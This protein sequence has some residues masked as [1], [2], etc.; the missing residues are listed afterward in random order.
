MTLYQLFAMNGY[1]IRETYWETFDG[2]MFGPAMRKLVI[3]ADFNGEV[4]DTNAALARFEFD[5]WRQAGWAAATGQIT[6][7]IQPY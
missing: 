7:F 6:D 2:S 1:A 3:W 4:Y 5:S